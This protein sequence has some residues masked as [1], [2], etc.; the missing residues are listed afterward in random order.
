MM[1]FNKVM[2]TSV[3]IVMCFALMLVLA[4]KPP[5]VRQ[6]ADAAKATVL[7][8]AAFDSGFTAERAQNLKDVIDNFVSD[9]ATDEADGT[10]RGLMVITIETA[11]NTNLITL[12]DYA[13]AQSLLTVLDG[14]FDSDKIIFSIADFKTVVKGFT[15]GLDV[16]IG[17]G[18][19]SRASVV[20]AG[21]E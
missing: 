13:L 1:R 9:S 7:L 19:V 11:Y 15:D 16:V 14:Y 20:Q 5:T 18:S 2:A 8:T 10:I 6:T 12:R 3:T 17:T 4:C 21:W